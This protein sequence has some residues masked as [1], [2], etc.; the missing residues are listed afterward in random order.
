MST[1]TTWQIKSTSSEATEQLG[2][3]LGKLLHGGEVIELISDLGGGKTTFTRGL[4]RGAGSEDRVA[5]PTFTISKLYRTPAFDIHHFDFYRLPEAGIM[6]EELSEVTADPQAVVVIEWADVVR[7]VLPAE[8]LT[9]AIR[10]TP[11]GARDI[12]LNTTPSL[13]YIIKGLA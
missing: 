9:V 1:D 2:E 11:D 4:V 8:R 12:T 7:D 10:Q 3:R 13:S 5:S 6:A